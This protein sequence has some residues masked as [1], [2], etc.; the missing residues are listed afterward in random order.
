MLVRVFQNTSYKDDCNQYKKDKSQYKN[1][2]DPKNEE[3]MMKD[4]FYY[5][6]NMIN[7]FSSTIKDPLS[8]MV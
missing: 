3:D 7:I 8:N 6:E 5:N 1:G 4:F 2:N